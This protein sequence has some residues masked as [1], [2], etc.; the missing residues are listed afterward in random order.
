MFEKRTT[1]IFK[2]V[3]FRLRSDPRTEQM[4]GTN[5]ELGRFGHVSGTVTETK[6]LVDCKFWVYGSHGDASVEVKGRRDNEIEWHFDKF[7]V[8]NESGRK[9]SLA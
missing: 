2:L 9:V 4:L 1:P 6:G 7:L 3:M 8:R 5:I